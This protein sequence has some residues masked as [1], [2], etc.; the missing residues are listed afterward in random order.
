MAR[1]MRPR[2]PRIVIAGE[3]DFGS[4]R[5]LEARL[6]ARAPAQG[7][8]RPLPRYLLIPLGAKFMSREPAQ[9]AGEDF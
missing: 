2:Y 8:F 6:A 4:G 3:T 5:I 7:E 1:R 9:S